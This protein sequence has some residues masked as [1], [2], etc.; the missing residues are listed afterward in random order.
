[1]CELSIDIITKKKG[2]TNIMFSTLTL[3]ASLLSFYGIGE[4]YKGKKEEKK[5]LTTKGIFMFGLGA[6]G[7]GFLNPIF[8]S[9]LLSSIC[10]LLFSGLSMGLV[11]H[12][13][14]N[15]HAEEI[16]INA[17]VQTNFE[18]EQK[19]DMKEITYTQSISS[20][21]IFTDFSKNKEIVMAKRNNLPTK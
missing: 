19:D 9:A 16:I 20:T 13:F 4:I 17:E 14:L 8:D 10:A 5:S 3:I 7:I 15:T 12:I 18:E 21:P 1:M 2:R 6:L 11:A